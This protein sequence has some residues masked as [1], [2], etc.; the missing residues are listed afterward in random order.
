MSYCVEIRKG[1]VGRISRCLI[2]L[3]A[4]GSLLGEFYCV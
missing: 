3:R 4:V 1:F 2:K